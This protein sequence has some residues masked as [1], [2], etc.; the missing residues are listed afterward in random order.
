[1]ARYLRPSVLVGHLLVLAAALT[2][3]RLG[4]WQWGVAHAA[5]GTVQNLGYALL[6]PVF[7][8]AFIYMWLRFLHL[9]S[10]R[11]M[12]AAG[13]DAQVVEPADDAGREADGGAAG[14]AGADTQPAGAAGGQPVEEDTDPVRGDATA[15]GVAEQPDPG[16]PDGAEP[17]GTR[18]RRGRP[19]PHEVYTI[20][21]AT[22]DDDD[23][24][25]PELAA[26]NKALAALAEQDRRRAR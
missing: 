14:V 25:D 12:E 1:M 23:D 4:W 11:D 5:R 6:W 3:L 24:D 17:S 16:I 7:A 15:D 10:V 22:V 9:E 8:G 2:C 26:Y 20:A 13:D 19:D 21:V 18:R